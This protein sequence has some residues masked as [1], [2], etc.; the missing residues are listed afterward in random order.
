MVWFHRGHRGHPD[1]RDTSHIILVLLCCSQIKDGCSIN[2][3]AD[4]FPSTPP[5]HPISTVHDWPNNTAAA[6][7]ISPQSHTRTQRRGNLSDSIRC[8]F[9]WQKIH[10][11]LTRWG[12]R[13]QICQCIPL[14]PRTV[15]IK[16]LALLNIPI[17]ILMVRCKHRA[18]IWQWFTLQRL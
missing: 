12:G 9:N 17:K 7:N 1:H 15:C 11:L 8:C 4:P 5:P 16:E 2:N 13:R 6:K 18:F 10:D 3:V 14:K